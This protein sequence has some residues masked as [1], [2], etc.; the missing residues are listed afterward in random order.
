M[1]KRIFKLGRLDPI[2]RPVSSTRNID[3]N[4]LHQRPSDGLPIGPDDADHPR[5]FEAEPC[6]IRFLPKSATAAALSYSCPTLHSRPKP[7]FLLQ[8]PLTQ[9]NILSPDERTVPPNVKFENRRRETGFC[10]SPSSWNSPP[11]R[12]TCRF[13][14]IKNNVAVPCPLSSPS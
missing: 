2:Q 13:P 3:R 10:F 9:C 5:S 7:R 12:G 4:L 14:K 1:P 8:L 6:S 11:S